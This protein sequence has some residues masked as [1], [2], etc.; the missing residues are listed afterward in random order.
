MDPVEYTLYTQHPEIVALSFSSIDRLSQ[1][2][3]IIRTHH[4]HNIFSR[5]SKDLF[6]FAY[7]AIVLPKK[8]TTHKKSHPS[9]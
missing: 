2:S 3:E 7:T 4:E 6:K 5:R 9:G 8:Y 1:V